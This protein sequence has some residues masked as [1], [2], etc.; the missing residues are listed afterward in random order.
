MFA[1]CETRKICGVHLVMVQTVQNFDDS[2]Y[3]PGVHWVHLCSLAMGAD[4]TNFAQST[5]TVSEMH[6]ICMIHSNFVEFSA[7]GQEPESIEL[8]WMNFVVNFA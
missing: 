3:F 4:S 1:E 2:L 5:G 7:D 8:M 6:K